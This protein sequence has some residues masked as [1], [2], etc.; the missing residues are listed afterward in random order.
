MTLRLQIYSR[1]ARWFEFCFLISAGNRCG[2]F[3]IPEFWN[4]PCRAPV[5]GKYQ[6]VRRSSV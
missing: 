3:A 5:P 4:S 1:N 2:N 6:K